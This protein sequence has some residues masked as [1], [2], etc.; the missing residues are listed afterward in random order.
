MQKI[1]N[2]LKCATIIIAL[3]FCYNSFA[4]QAIPSVEQAFALELQAN[5]NEL[6]AHWSIAPNTYLYQ[7][8]IEFQTPNN[9]ILEPIIFPTGES[10]SDPD[11]GEQIIY[12]N[13]L[14]LNVKL[15]TISK[16]TTQMPLSVRYQGCSSAGFCYPPKTKNFVMHIEN[17]ALISIHKADANLASGASFMISNS[18]APASVAP[19]PVAVP[20]LFNTQNVFTLF[21]GCFVLGV[22]LCFTPCVLPMVPML[23]T[24]IVGKKNL[25]TF[26]AFSLSSIYVLSMSFTY[27]IAGVIAAMLGQRIQT[28][29][30]SPWVLSAFATLFVILG[31]EL[32]GHLSI[33]LPDFIKSR[34]YQ[35]QT[36]S[37]SGTFLGAIALGV[38][39][40]LVASPCVSAPLMGVLGYITQTGNLLVGG[41][42][43]FAIGLGMGT[44]LIIAGTLGGKYLPKA[45]RW[46][47]LINY[48]FA[49]LLFAFAI[50]IVE[51]FLPAFIILPLWALLCLYVAY[52]MGSFHT[53]ISGI[54]PRVGVLFIVYSGFLIFG[55]LQG[56]TDPF[57]PLMLANK[58][59][60]H[61]AFN[62][63]SSV[64]ALDQTL[65]T[66]K[67]N[68]Q[69]TIVEF[70]ADWC[71]SC[72][73]MEKNT[74]HHP[75][76]QAQLKNWHLVQ[77]N[78]TQNSE[79]E[80][81]LLKKFELIGPPSILFF[82]KNGN[83]H[84][85][86]RLT[87]EVDAEKFIEHLKKVQVC[88]NMRD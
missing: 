45:G 13:Q 63:L 31:L 27:A 40:T 83:E 50:W 73:K 69:P 26:R 72:K 85:H 6:S 53:K 71:V 20:A 54:M 77:A 33:S 2:F 56:A 32:A 87:G 62:T 18:A 80:Q 7:S 66:A 39:A 14:D 15:K 75:G 55:T 3:T 38:L 42:S 10:H 8:K 52:K 48:S 46:M 57:K 28:L 30:Q 65:E 5:K 36:K 22:V 29:F 76:V 16:K 4:T 49:V 44:P 78:V 47:E 74:L 60:E 19:A 79:N 34:L 61:L 70:Y 21:F 81:A 88:H 17:G 11:F 84:V 86:L 1:S 24:L 37:T 58:A 41:L 64:S 51:R 35:L 68:Q 82:D 23:S 9:T 67:K 25:K 59:S 43:L 12:K